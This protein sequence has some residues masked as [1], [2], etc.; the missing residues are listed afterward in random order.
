LE[1]AADERRIEVNEAEIL[2]FEKLVY[3]QLMPISDIYRLDHSTYFC[4]M[5]NSYDL[6][7]LSDIFDTDWVIGCGVDRAD[8]LKLSSEGARTM[9]S[10]IAKGLPGSRSNAKF[11]T[12]DDLIDKYIYI[13]LGIQHVVDSSL[14]GVKD[15]IIKIENEFS[16][17]D[18]FCSERWGMFDIGPWLE[19][20]GIEVEI[21]HPTPAKQKEG[22]SELYVAVA[23]ERFKCPPIGYGGSTGKDILYEEMEMIET[24]PG[25]DWYGS[26]EKNKL[27]GVQDDTVF[28]IVWNIYGLRFKTVDDMQPRKGK[29]YFG[30][31][32]KN[33]DL[34]GSYGE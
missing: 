28:S 19:D 15:A 29:S 18:V 8:P 3:S 23:N 30:E 27:N 33:R 24:T 34:L 26:P 20:R 2:A 12:Q 25:K 17:I 1:I 32:I 7:K 4:D 31:F 13:V 9:V 10:F 22:F 16:F 14:E 6:E 21:I 11:H 5:A